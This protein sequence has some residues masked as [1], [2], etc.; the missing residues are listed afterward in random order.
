MTLRLVECYTLTNTK[1]FSC[2]KEKDAIR[3]QTDIDTLERWTSMWLMK[4]HPN[5][6]HVLTL[7]K[8]TDIRY[9][10]EYKVCNNVI[11]HVSSER[12]LGIVIDEELSFDEHICTKVRISNALVGQ[13]RR[14]FSFLDGETLK[15]L[16]TSL[17]RPHLEYGQSVW[18]PF[19]MRHINMIERVQERATKLVDGMADL[20]YSER[21][22]KLG[23]TTLRFRR[24]RGDL[25]EMHKHFHLHDKNAIT[26]PSFQTRDRPSR[27]HNHQ[28]LEQA[29][30]R[31][32]GMREN[33]FYGRTSRI[34]NT[35]PR[36]VAESKT[37]NSFKNALDKHFEQHPLKHNHR[38]TEHVPLM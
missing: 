26:G 25:I 27:R 32:R 23:L 9:A 5:K 38:D 4:F 34:W 20:D 15:K 11:E 21:L 31:E 16:F 28:V 12:D 18:S 35:L 10:H 33:S 14:T 19:L 6:C 30:T 8:F 36:N 22:K 2:I 13:I 17:V 3:L 24:L 37:V 1:I 7:G 29:R